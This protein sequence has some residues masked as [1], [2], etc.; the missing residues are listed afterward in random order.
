MNLG[1]GPDFWAARHG[2]LYTARTG[3]TVLVAA[4]AV[5][6]SFAALSLLQAVFAVV[7]LPLIPRDNAGLDTSAEMIAQSA[8]VKSM[9]VGLF[10]ASLI[11]AVVAWFF[12]GKFNATGE[13][14]IPLHMPKLG[15][16][17]WVT[18]I[19]GLLVTMWLV[20]TLTFV[21]LGIDPST[22]A[23]NKE[24]L[25]DV[26][27]SAGLVE[28]AMADLAKDPAL[29]ALAMPGVAI[30][31]PIVE[32]V[33]FRGALFSALRN[34]WF[35]KTGAVVLSAAAWASVHAVSSPLLFVFVIF[36]M[37]LALGWLLLRFGSL[38]VTIVC[39]CCW[40]AFSSLAI[41][42]AQVPQ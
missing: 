28:K 38:W 22:Y 26:N 10:P 16:L 29:F 2:E 30:A 7:M 40:N 23:T 17:G 27:S 25:N 37:G 24:G 21:L 33:I 41:F 3:Q 6:A 14:G 32:E 20:F 36:I 11:G 34:S 9:I 31:V 12:A 42:G 13:T 35:G 18:I 5:V 19:I 39:H 15:A 4:L 8:F 1:F